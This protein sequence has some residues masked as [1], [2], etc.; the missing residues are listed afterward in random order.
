MGKYFTRQELTYSLK[1]Y[2]YKIDNTPTEEV[3][4][5]LIELIEVLDDI[6]VKW[7]GPIIVTSGYRCEEL[8]QKV[9]GSKNSAHKYGF[10]VD[11]RPA[12]NKI[13]KFF[14]FMKEYLKDK[15]FDECLLESDS[16]GSVWLHFALKS[17]QGKQRKKVKMLKA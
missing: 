2:K 9:G 5:N 15:S 10:G 17:Y 3:I 14:E 16:Q 11:L 13:M 7:G 12:N 1:A 8:N 4:S 6:R